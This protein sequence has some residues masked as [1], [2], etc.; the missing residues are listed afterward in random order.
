PR[1]YPRGLDTEVILFSALEKSWRED[2]DLALREHVTQY[3][4]QNP[5]L[6]TIAGFMHEQDNSSLRWTVDMQEDLDLITR[7]YTYFGNTAFSWRDVLDLVQKNPELT[8]I[9]KHIQQKEIKQKQATH[10]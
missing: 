10:R 2:T 4:V 6:F 8:M 7:I 3:I 9:N 1:T 5:E